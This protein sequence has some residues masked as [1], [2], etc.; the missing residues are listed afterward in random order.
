MDIE[1]LTNPDMICQ[2]V[3]LIPGALHILTF[4]YLLT[5]GVVDANISIIL[6][7]QL[8]EEFVA[9]PSGVYN[10][11]LFGSQIQG[12]NQLCFNGDSQDPAH[13]TGVLI[14]DIQLTMEQRVDFIHFVIEVDQNNN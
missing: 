8:I 4:K 1:P 6:N 9:D 10:N 14:D 2:T 3:D 11:T 5:S 13:S 12:I 7:S